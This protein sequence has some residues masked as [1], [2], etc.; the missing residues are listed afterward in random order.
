MKKILIFENSVYSLLLFILH[1]KNWNECD[2]VF[3][4]ERLP[5]SVREN[6]KKIIKGKGT[7]ENISLSL[8]KHTLISYIKMLK[9]LKYKSN[10]YDLICGNVREISFFDPQKT[11]QISDGVMTIQEIK[12]N[13]YSDVLSLP[14]KFRL[15]LLGRRRF[16]YMPP[17]KYLLETNSWSEEK[18]E[19]R[20]IFV[21]M[22]KS[23]NSL[24]H[25]QQKRVLEVFSLDAHEFDFGYRNTLL[26]TQP[27]NEEGFCSEGD[28]KNGYLRLINDLNINHE[29]LIIK[30]HP[31]E[32]TDYKKCFP[33][34]FIL[35]SHFPI[36]L[37]FLM[38]L[39]FEK[40]ITL[41]STVSYFVPSNVILYKM[42]NIDY[43]NLSSKVPKYKAK[44][45]GDI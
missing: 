6:I 30:P 29:H 33:K 7:T 45:L 12:N 20:I 25:Y 17:K 18:I 38:G 5:I 41:W 26:V 14:H 2:Y 1:N 43:F 39:P 19:S 10:E 15:I 34:A 32:L 42:G 4:G 16:K 22:K 27:L 44:I 35:P 28:K 13:L 8:R 31:R 36:E 24:G 11:I 3:F 40:L 23:W 21:D 37:L 9:H